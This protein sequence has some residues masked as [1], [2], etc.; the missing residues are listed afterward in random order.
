MLYLNGLLKK[1]KNEYTRNKILKMKNN[2]FEIIKELIHWEEV[3]NE[4]LP[5][6]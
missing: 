2:L 4:S 1:H 3:V 6:F 5:I